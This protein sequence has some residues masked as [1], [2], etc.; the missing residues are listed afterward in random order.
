MDV[1]PA[2]SGNREK[3]SVI[4]QLGKVFAGIVV[5]LLSSFLLSIRKHHRQ[6][7]LREFRDSRIG[8][9]VT[10]SAVASK[11]NQTTP[12]M[13]GGDME[14]LNAA[15]VENMLIY[16]YRVLSST[17]AAMDVDQFRTRMSTKLLASACTTPETRDEFLKKGVAL[18]YS[19]V[20]KNHKFIA[21][22]DVTPAACGF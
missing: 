18:R 10:L 21:A 5:V 2:R 9:S 3:P 14:M 19:Y 17:V 12:M 11:I 8:S 7:A 4:I 20:D 13:V 22:I 1:F 16:N 15:G 6:E